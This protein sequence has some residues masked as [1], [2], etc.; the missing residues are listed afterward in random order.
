M[1]IYSFID[2]FSSFLPCVFTLGVFDGVHKGHQKIIKNLV[3]RA[4]KEKLFCSV[5][6]T[7]YPH[8]KEILEPNKE[9]FYLNTLSERIYNLKKTGIQHLIIHPFTINFSKLSTKD[10][11][12]KIVSSRLKIKQ[13]IT[14]YDSHIGKNRD[15]SF[16]HLKNLSPIYGFKLYQVNPCK[17]NKKI[18]SSTSIRKSLIK[19]NIEWANKALGYSY[20]LSGFVIQGNGIGRILNYPT[21]NIR[22]DN[23]KLIPKQGVYAVKINYLHNTYQGMLNIGVCPT[24]RI[25]NNKKIKIEVHIFDFHKNIYGKEIDILILK[26][27]REEKKFRTIQ[28]LKT[29]I[30]K[31]QIKIKKFFQKFNN[32]CEK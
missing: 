23:K 26:I 1:K 10:F 27:I 24:I 14:G 2:E 7:F 16:H 4:K 17:S 32:H 13:F 18:I 15:G 30:N 9:I 25:R 19:G 8:P 21:A 22:I 31:D 6:L 11:L 29:Q 3:F 5:L 28:D 12:Q 20:T